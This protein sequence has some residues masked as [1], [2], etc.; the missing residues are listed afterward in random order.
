MFN[1]ASSYELAFGRGKPFLNQSPFLNT[2]VGG[3]QLSG[4]FNAQSGLPLAISG[5]CDQLTCRPNL[6]GNPHFPGG[7]SK[8]ERISQWINPAAFSPPFGTD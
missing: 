4:T 1:F 2:V 7:R 8:A 5:P 3:W 6:I